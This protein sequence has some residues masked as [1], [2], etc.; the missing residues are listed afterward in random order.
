MGTTIKPILHSRKNKNNEYPLA[1]RIYK[2]KKYSLVFLGYTIK[3]E[4]WDIKNRCVK[5]NHPNYKRLNAYII[6]RISEVNN[7]HL[8]LELEDKDSS[9]DKIHKKTLNKNKFITFNEQASNYMKNL[10][11]EGKF[12]RISTGKPRIKRFNEF[13]KGKEIFLKDIT[14][15]LLND[16]RAWLKATK[17]IG[18]RT[19]VNHLVIIRTIFNQ[20]IKGGTVEQK[21]YPFGKG[22]IPI[23]FPQSIKIGLSIDEVRNM[24]ELDLAH[25]PA[26][27][28]ARNLWLFSFYLAGM[29]ISDVLRLKHSDIKDNRLVYKM[30]K[31]EKV[32]SLKIP[33]KAIAIL[34]QYEKFK[35][36]ND[37]LIFPDL[38]V[39]S[40]LSN[41]YEVQKRISSINGNLNKRLKTIAKLINL[42][43]V[44]LTSHLAR[45]TFG[46]ISGDKIPIQMLKKLYRHSSITTTIDYQSNF[47]FKDTDDALDSVIDF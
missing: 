32:G 43:N 41:K 27:N 42:K 3:K 34:N 45:H 30:G 21:Y 36:K 13:L 37:D 24:E 1:I 26:C 38:K 40:D 12:N 25:S 20:A 6:K 4:Q 28:H 15:P 46:N 5:R 44:T 17:N 11:L 2:D 19:I 10:K 23:K 31:N 47:I 35:L 18:E 16:Y 14:V 29:R 7:S 9:A 8:V 39:I 33:N 22:K